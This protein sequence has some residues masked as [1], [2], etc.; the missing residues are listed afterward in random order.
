MKS[1]ADPEEP[2]SGM[3]AADAPALDCI[4]R[5]VSSEIVHDFDEVWSDSQHSASQKLRE[6]TTVVRRSRS[7]VEDAAPVPT[8][9][10][11]N[12]AGDSS[13]LF[14]EAPKTASPKQPSFAIKP[15]HHLSAILRKSRS[16]M[17]G[18]KN[19]SDRTDDAAAASQSLVQLTSVMRGS[20]LGKQAKGDEPIISE[21]PIISPK[22]SDVSV[23][24]DEDSESEDCG[25]ENAGIEDPEEPS[26]DPKAPSPAPPLKTRTGKSGEVSPA[27]SM[28]NQKIQLEPIDSTDH[29]PPSDSAALS[30]SAAATEQLRQLTAVVRKS[31]SELRLFSSSTHPHLVPFS[32]TV[33]V[34]ARDNTQRKEKLAQDNDKLVSP[35]D[36][37]ANIHQETKKKE[38]DDETGC[39]LPSKRLGPQTRTSSNGILSRISSTPRSSSAAHHALSTAELR[40]IAS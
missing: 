3:A 38:K 32:I 18:K 27:P 23:S 7:N 29:V 24:N 2:V 39:K 40:S 28:Q 21:T 22:G 16:S 9:D 5:G 10:A 36:S 17:S 26:K 33:P 34:T 37:T 31:R 25:S 19:K 12:V 6:L 15:L 30:P 20:R 35:R 8:S 4:V 11:I 13:L 14:A 1:L